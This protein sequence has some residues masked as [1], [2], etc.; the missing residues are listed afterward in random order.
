M[1]GRLQANWDFPQDITAGRHPNL[2]TVKY[3]VIEA[4]E[5]ELT[6]TTIWPTASSWRI[7]VVCAQPDMIIPH[8][9]LQV[10]LGSRRHTR[11]I[12]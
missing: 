9:E 3:H 7:M 8:W 12:P 4:T 1:L 2:Q 6:L 5:A 11:S 10:M